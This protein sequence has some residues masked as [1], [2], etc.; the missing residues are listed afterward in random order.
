M[1]SELSRKLYEL[2]KCN[3][4]E[5]YEVSERCNGKMHGPFLISPNSKFSNSKI[6]VIF[7]GQETN[8][9]S[10]ERNIS[11]QMKEYSNFNLGENY[12]SSPFW[13]VIRK[14]EASIIGDTHSSSWLNLNRYDE[15]CK[16]PSRENLKVL[17]DFDD[18]LLSELQILHPDVTIF[19]TG[20]SYDRRIMS[21]L[22]AE[23]EPLENLDPKTVCEFNASSINGR[24]FRTYHPNYLRRSGLED[25][26]ISEICSQINV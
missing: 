23:K 3:E 20:H 15:N 4:V 7:V 25:K 12:Y 8:G 18:L 9:W 1:S 24:I 22:D 19:L 6:K 2:Y 10:C 16:K 21:L 26:V 14:F 11:D 13:N 5:L 17:A